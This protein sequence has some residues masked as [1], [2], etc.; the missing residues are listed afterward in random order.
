MIF[1]EREVIEVWCR[2]HH[3]APNLDGLSLFEYHSYIKMET[4]IGI[5]EKKWYLKVPGLN[6]HS[7]GGMSPVHFE[8]QVTVRRLDFKQN[9]KYF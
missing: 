4:P 6:Y 7:T 9:C 8:Q 5:S 1:R 3:S 2:V